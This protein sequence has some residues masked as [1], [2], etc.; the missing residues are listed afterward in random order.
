MSVLASIILFLFLKTREIVLIII[1]R[2]LLLRKMEL[3]RRG[4]GEFW[5]KGLKMESLS[6]W[7]LLIGPLL[8][9]GFGEELRVLVVLSLGL[10]GLDFGRD[11]LV[12]ELKMRRLM[13]LLKIPK[14]LRP[15]RRKLVRFYVSGGIAGAKYLNSSVYTDSV[16]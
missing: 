5:R 14:E 13:R 6:C 16:Y 12:R 10:E 1:L 15:R 3:L 7:T 2:G 9:G 4:K 11:G 8:C